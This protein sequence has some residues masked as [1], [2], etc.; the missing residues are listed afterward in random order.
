MGSM[1]CHC[2]T[3]RRVSAAPTVAWVTFPSDRFAIV[4]G[5]PAQFSSSQEVRRTFCPY[6]G[7][8][9]TYERRD[10][11][12]S[13]DITTCSLD[14]PDAFAPTHHS[15]IGHDIGWMR[16]CDNLPKYPKSRHDPNT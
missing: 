10:E 2:R 16:S 12:Q 9:L 3:C 8:P 4:Q 7:T 13:I 6:C 5:E 1:I 14:E 15:W 11:P